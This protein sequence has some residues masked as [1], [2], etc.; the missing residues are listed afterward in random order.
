MVVGPA[1]R[2]ASAAK[3]GPL[4]NIPS[5]PWQTRCAAAVRDC[6]PNGRE[7]VIAHRCAFAVDGGPGRQWGGDDA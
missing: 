2:P 4:E 1:V 7:W 6:R 3:L 5:A